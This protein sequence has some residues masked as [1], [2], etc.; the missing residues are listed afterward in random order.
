[1]RC[2]YNVSSIKLLK[3]FSLKFVERHDL[4]KALNYEPFSSIQ[5]YSMYICKVC[6]VGQMI[7][8]SMYN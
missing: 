6:Y 2:D 7:N 5:I 8:D 1:M 4:P 3:V